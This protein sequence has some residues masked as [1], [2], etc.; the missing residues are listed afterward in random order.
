MGTSQRRKQSVKGCALPKCSRQVEFKA[1]NEQK[2]GRKKK[3]QW[4]QERGRPAQYGTRDSVEIKQGK[5]KR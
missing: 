1:A 3:R 2:L 5:K 4:Y